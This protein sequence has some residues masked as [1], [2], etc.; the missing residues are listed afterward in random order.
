M[1]LLFQVLEKKG[2]KV[3]KDTAFLKRRKGGFGER[4]IAEGMGKSKINF[5]NDRRRN[6]GTWVALESKE[7]ERRE[8]ARKKRRGLRKQGGWVERRKGE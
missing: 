7:G 1:D 2:K 5:L 4:G 3:D 6:E 8:L